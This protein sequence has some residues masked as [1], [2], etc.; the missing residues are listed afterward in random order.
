MVDV[1]TKVVAETPPVTLADRADWL[2]GPRNTQRHRQLMDDVAC[3]TSV[4]HELRGPVDVL[5]FPFRV[6]A[7]NL[8]RCYD[9][10]GAT[11]RLRG[12]DVVLLSEMDVGMA[13]TRQVD[14]VAE[15]SRQLDAEA[16]FAVEFIELGWGN[17]RETEWSQGRPNDLGLH[18]NAVLA[19][20]PLRGV[21]LW[22]LDT[23]GGRWFAPGSP[24]PRVGGRCAVGGQVM[25]PD[26]PVWAVSV[27]LEYSG[28]PQERADDVCRLLEAMAPVVG[29]APVILGGDFNTFAV[30]GHDLSAE[31]LFEVVRRQGFEVHAGPEAEV[32]I[33]RS[34]VSDHTTFFR[35]DWVLTRGLVVGPC[36]VLPAVKDHGE[37]L[38]DH[39][40]LSLEVLGVMDSSRPHHGPVTLD[41]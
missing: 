24:E 13:R 36:R 2:L 8:E 41:F 31:P 35:L 1:H 20:S 10:T 26:G 18:G 34:R 23:D 16:L 11:Q 22:R 32:T 25:T 7:W 37:P 3:L 5:R 14:T 15:L 17:P 19:R 12:H 6:A 33:R 29:D 39:E 27:H 30:A 28:T 21:H 40:V 38:S 9:V 4:R